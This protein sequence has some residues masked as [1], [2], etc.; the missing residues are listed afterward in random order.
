[1]F[2]QYLFVFGGLAVSRLADERAAAAEVNVDVLKFLQ[3]PASEIFWSRWVRRALV[4]ATFHCTFASPELAAV[5]SVAI[6]TVVK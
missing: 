4:S 5:V 2:L 3:S 1:L 6:R